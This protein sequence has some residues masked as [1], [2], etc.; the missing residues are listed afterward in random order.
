[1]TNFTLKSPHILC[2]E[3][4]VNF[5]YQSFP[6]ASFWTYFTANK[7]CNKLNRFLE[8]KPKIEHDEVVYDDQICK[9]SKIVPSLIQQNIENQ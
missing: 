2:W 7:L 9:M 4:W 5:K 8:I 1:M 3:V 6:I